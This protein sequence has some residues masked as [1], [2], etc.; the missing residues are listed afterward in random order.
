MFVLLVSFKIKTQAPFR[1]KTRLEKEAE[2]HKHLSQNALLRWWFCPPAP[3]ELGVI[4]YW[5]LS[6]ANLS[7]WI[8]TVLLKDKAFL[9]KPVFVNRTEEVIFSLDRKSA[10]LCSFLSQLVVITS[11]DKLKI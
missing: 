7:L 6:G 9:A 8:T 5:V 11:E 10:V 4:G 1:G 2:I 3:P